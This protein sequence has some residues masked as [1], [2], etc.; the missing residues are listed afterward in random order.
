VSDPIEL[1]S[2]LVFETQNQ[3]LT[4]QEK[5]PLI[6]KVKDKVHLI[7]ISKA[8]SLSISDLVGQIDNN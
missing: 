8:N 4:A 5:K 3:I 7:T 1:I 6:L 2:S